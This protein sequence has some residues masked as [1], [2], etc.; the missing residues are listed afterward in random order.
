MPTEQSVGSFYKEFTLLKM[1]AT[2]TVIA[3]AS[4]ATVS[5][6]KKK[7][8]DKNDNPWAAV[9]AVE[10]ISA[11]HQGN[12]LSLFLFHSMKKE[13]ECY[14]KNAVYKI[15]NK[16]KFTY[17]LFLLLI[18]KSHHPLHLTEI[19]FIK[20]NSQIWRFYYAISFINILS[21]DSYRFS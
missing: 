13:K 7:D 19:F 10:I 20:S 15:S 6:C 17:C 14:I 2:A 4:A 3:S 11:S 1:S 8:D 18:Y 16:I 5:A 21:F 9:T 12:L